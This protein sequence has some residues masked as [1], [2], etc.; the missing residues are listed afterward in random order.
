M[1]ITH[2][3]F[4]DLVWFVFSAG[5]VVSALTIGVLWLY[6]RPRATAP[7][8]FLM[9]SA[10]VYTLASMFAVSHTAAR[11]L[12]LGYRPLQRADVPAGRSAV[13]LLAA[14]NDTVRDWSGNRLSNDDTITASRVLEAARVFHL[15]DP[16]WVIS[17]GGLPQDNGIQV[18]TA[19]TMRDTLV[20]LGVPASRIIMETK[21]LNTYAEAT[22]VAPM[23][24][25]LQIEHTIVVTS[26][27]HMRRS[28]GAFRTQG[29]EP[30]P[31]IAR[32][33]YA[34]MERGQM[35]LPSTGGLLETSLATHEVLGILYY[36]LR[37]WYR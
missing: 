13:V 8:R 17:S 1:T 18:P 31:A 26:E 23:L 25:S 10:V 37:G 28:I 29:I 22:I 33:P 2:S 12:A 20:R 4:S 24:E 16:E 5:G 19:I 11:V 9:A 6:A 21:S 14:G 35:F 32:H 36:A 7:R 27:F 15:V 3:G 30:I 34:D